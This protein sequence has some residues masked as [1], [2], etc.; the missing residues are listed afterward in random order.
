MLQ[1]KNALEAGVDD[2]IEFKVSDFKDLDI[3]EDYGVIISN[4]PYGER[5]LEQEEA[6]KLYQDLGKKLLNTDTHS[7]Y[8]LTSFTD[9]EKAYGKKANKRRKLYNG[10]IETWYY[11]YYGPKPE[12]V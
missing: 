6:F 12:G 5:L 9:F 11:Q 7:V 3:P 2:C 4:P 10:R 1:S 8:M